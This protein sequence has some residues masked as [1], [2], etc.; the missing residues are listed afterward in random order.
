VRKEQADTG[1]RGIARGKRDQ[2]SLK[3]LR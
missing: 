1:A 2:D 3:A